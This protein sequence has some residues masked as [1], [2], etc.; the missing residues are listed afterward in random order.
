VAIFI[1]GINVKIARE[2]EGVLRT[3][4][5][6]QRKEVSWEAGVTIIYLAPSFIISKFKTD[7]DLHD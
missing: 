7:H 6:L 2:W 1:A 4:K 3:N 5:H